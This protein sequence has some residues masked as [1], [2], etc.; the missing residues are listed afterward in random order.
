[1]PGSVMLYVVR[2]VSRCMLS[3]LAIWQGS[4]RQA[5]MEKSPSMPPASASFVINV[6]GVR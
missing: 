6:K 3:G 4:E 5:F 1:M 2:Q